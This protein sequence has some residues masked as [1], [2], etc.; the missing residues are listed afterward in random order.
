MPAMLGRNLRR[1]PMLM[2][3]A[4]LLGA[5][6][7]DAATSITVSASPVVAH[8]SSRYIS[9]AVDLDQVT[10]GMFW[11]QAPGARGNAPVAPYDFTRTRLRL[12]AHAL[13]PA[14]LRIS[15]TAANKT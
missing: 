5:A 6:E 14:Y 9:F 2:A 12:L 3:A 15:G 8:T 13:A 1:I 10:G 11:S 4:L 7:A